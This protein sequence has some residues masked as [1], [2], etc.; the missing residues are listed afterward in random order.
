MVTAVK[1]RPQLQLDEKVLHRPELEE[2]LDERGK[3]KE[4]VGKARKAYREADE[5]ARG[6]IL[7]MD[8]AHPVRVGRWQLSKEDR[9]GRSVAFETGPRTAVRIR[10]VVED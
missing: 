3:L 6:I 4:R 5:Q 10:A 2:L 9:P 1:A 8:L 7:E